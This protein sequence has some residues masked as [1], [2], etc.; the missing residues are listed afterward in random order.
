MVDTSR[1]TCAAAVISPMV[2]FLTRR[3]V[4]MAAT[5]RGEISPFMIMRIRCSISS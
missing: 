1:I 4:V 3:P 5:M 2:S